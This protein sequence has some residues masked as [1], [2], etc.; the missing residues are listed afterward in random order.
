MTVEAQVTLKSPANERPGEAGA[1]PPGPQLPE[2]PPESGL[3]PWLVIG[4]AFALGLVI[5]K[6]IAWRSRADSGS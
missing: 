5:A 2:Q 1:P 4:V 3:N 6:I